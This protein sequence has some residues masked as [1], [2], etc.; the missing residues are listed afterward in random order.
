MQTVNINGYIFEA[1]TLNTSF[2][3]VPGVYVIYTRQKWLDVGETDKLG[4]RIPS[5]E[6]RNCW[7]NNADKLPINLAFLY[8]GSQTQRFNIEASLRKTLNPTCGEKQW[9]A[10]EIGNCTKMILCF[11]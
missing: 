11:T 2:T 1:Y 5:H 6:R 4:Q 9:M 8:V 7:V 3:D 10:A